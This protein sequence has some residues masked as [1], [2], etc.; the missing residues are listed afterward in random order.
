M[1]ILYKERNVRKMLKKQLITGII[2]IIIIMNSISFS[3]N[4]YIWSESSET[5]SSIEE[6]QSVAS[7]ITGENVENNNSLNLQCG[8]A[9]LIEQETGQILYSHN[10]HEQLRPASVTKVMS[11]L[12]I[13]EQSIKEC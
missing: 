10:V 8:S 1:Y 4:I 2:A 12:L 13:M 5:S 11:L 6:T 3:Q 9:I 7:I